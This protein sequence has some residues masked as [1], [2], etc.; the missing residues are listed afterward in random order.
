MVNQNPAQSIIE[1]N[2]VEEI[3]PG[4]FQTRWL[5]G[6]MGN[7]SLIAYGGCALGAGT[8][9]A[10]ETV[11]DTHFI[12]S[13]VGHYHGPASI[14][15]PLEMFVTRTRDTKTFATRRVELRQLQ[16]DGKTKRTVM[17][18]LVDFHID[19]PAAL[20]F[21][22]QPTRSYARW[23]AVPKDINAYGDDKSAA[24]ANKMFGLNKRYFET[25]HCPE[26]VAGQNLHG[27]LK[28]R[29]HNQD[30][31]PLGQRSSAEWSKAKHDL[32]DSKDTNGNRIS[33]RGDRAAAVSFLM[34]GGLSFLP[35]THNHMWMEDTGACSSLD[36]ALRF[37]VP[38]IDLGKEWHL[39]E[40]TTISGA[41]GRTYSEARLW[42]EKGELV[43]SMT[44]S[45]I[46]RP[47]KPAPKDKKGSML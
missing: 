13:L 30:H 10:Y 6:H 14:S 1:Q 24:A 15:Q 29:S 19:E 31:L 26:G 18:M 35:L 25:R 27:M 20:E 7:A 37:M 4:H 36:F 9:A 40:R 2:A 5:P 17:E 46:L 43:A 41:K 23:D 42:D 8:R 16:A 11:P 21:S 39:R 3:A 44:Q 22:A 33:R 32:S 12:Y 45:S 34:D 47:P 38:D 28:H